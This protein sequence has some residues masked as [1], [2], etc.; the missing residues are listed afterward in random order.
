MSQ[1]NTFE[2]EITKK[3]KIE[4]LGICI[5]GETTPETIG[6]LRG[7][8]LKRT[9]HLSILDGD[10]YGLLFPNNGYKAFFSNKYFDSSIESFSKIKITADLY[11]IGVHEGSYGNLSE[12]LEKIIMAIKKKGLEK[13]NQPI[14]HRFM[15]D[16]RKTVSRDLRTEIWI[17]TI[18]KT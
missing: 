9:D 3:N 17:P 13:K 4:G 12:S 11:A 6:L 15:N 2:I 10:C 16:P 5:A 8:F 1:K 14:V 18:E 7:Q